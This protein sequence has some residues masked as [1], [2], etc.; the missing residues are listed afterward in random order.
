MSIH[1]ALADGWIPGSA[2][3]LLCYHT[4]VSS[5]K[6]TFP[7]S[8]GALAD[9]AMKA[10][11]TTTR[12]PSERRY[13]TIMFIDMVGYTRLSEELDP[14]DLSAVV[15][16]YQQLALT[17]M[18]R[19]GG[20]VASFAGDGVMVYFGYPTAHGNDAERAV[21][22]AALEMVARIDS[23]DI[24]GFG[25]A[26]SALS[27]RIGLH[28]GLVVVGPERMS[29]GSNLHG[30]VGE[31]AN[32]A[33]R[34]QNE[35]PNKGV[36]I[37]RD[38]Q[39]LVGRLFDFSPPWLPSGS[40]ACRGRWEAFQVFRAKPEAETGA[41][42]P[43][44][45]AARMIGRDAALSR[46]MARWRAAQT[47]RR[48]EV[49]VVLGEAGV[50]K[51]RLIKEF[52]SHPSLGEAAIVQTHC[53]EISRAAARSRRSAATSGSGLAS[54]PRLARP[55]AREAETVSRAPR[56]FGRG[57]RSPYG[58]RAGLW[59]AVS[60]VVAPG[61]EP[62][63]AEASFN[64]SRTWCEKR[65]KAGR[66]FFRSRT[67]IGLTQPP[68]SFSVSSPIFSTRPRSFCCSPRA[69][70]PRGRSWPR[71]GRTDPDRAVDA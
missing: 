56:R 21:R 63:Q 22:R 23:L 41:S 61:S 3:M 36:V 44:Q 54:S 26:P 59:G 48:R 62:L 47:E 16:R 50:G 53:H 64:S 45:D 60:S 34:L 14:E 24:A 15:G 55:A 32:V 19:F 67:P 68:P 25:L 57:R 6:N 29:S 33:A 5:R 51:S 40:R 71:A 52:F 12:S 7:D 43:G 42:E 11:R 37:S 58:A 2:T 38:T 10:D 49:V 66:S 8:M 46:L 39:R 13:L 70:F 69:P 4:R 17:V 18:E 1:H 20:F 65:S 27:V 28:T 35:A 30:V 31:A 9:Q